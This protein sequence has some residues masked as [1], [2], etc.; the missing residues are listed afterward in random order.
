[1]AYIRHGTI[2]PC[3]RRQNKYRM[4]SYRDCEQ[5]GPLVHGYNRLWFCRSAVVQIFISL[6]WVQIGKNCNS[7]PLQSWAWRWLSVCWLQICKVNQ[8]LEHPPHQLSHSSAVWMSLPCYRWAQPS[9][10]LPFFFFHSLPAFSLYPLSIPKGFLSF[11]TIMSELEASLILWAW[12]VRYWGSIPPKQLF[13]T[14]EPSEASQIERAALNICIN[15]RALSRWLLGHAQAVLCPQ[16]PMPGWDPDAERQRYE[17]WKEAKYHP[18]IPGWFPASFS[19]KGEK[20]CSWVTQRFGEC[21]SAKQLNI[22][23]PLS[24]HLER[25]G[26]FIFITFFSPF[27]FGKYRNFFKAF[28]SF[29]APLLFC[30]SK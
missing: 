4:L 24:G 30:N 22:A 29:G 14:Q 25:H 19:N 1:M 6:F 28:L 16:G 18:E 15:Y 20:M 10:R 21:F 13:L 17:E 11:R 5:G 2:T 23:L 9:P 7:R 26:L 12:G 8:S 27:F 3:C